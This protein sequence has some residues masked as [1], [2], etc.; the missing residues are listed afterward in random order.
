MALFERML[1]LSSK[2]F[3]C[4]QIMMLLMLEAEEEENPGLIRALGAFNNGFRDTGLVCGAFTGGACVISYYAGQGDIDELADPAYD[5]MVQ[6]FFKWFDETFTDQYGGIECPV[7]LAG[8]K[9]NR[10]ARCP[11][12]VES[13]LAKVVSILEDRDLL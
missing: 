2:G 11:G 4:A 6:E 13:S 7:I 10:L 1:E 5:G 8:D 3:A 9:S 12:I